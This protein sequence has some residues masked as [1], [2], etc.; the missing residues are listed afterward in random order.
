MQN[1]FFLDAEM[2]PQ[3]NPAQLT[4]LPALM[5]QR[6][7]K[8]LDEKN[9]VNYFSWFQEFYKNKASLSAE[10]GKVCSI[11]AG[12]LIGDKFYLKTI[13]DD[14][15]V[16]VL[17]ALT[18]M[19]QDGKVKCNTLVGHNIIDFDIP[20]LMRRYIVHRLPIPRLINLMLVKKMWEHPV[21][22]T[23]KMWG[24]AQFNYRV[25]LDLLCE[26]FGIPSAK[27]EISGAD[28]CDLYYG[29]GR[30]ARAN[31]TSDLP[32]EKSDALKKIG[33]YNG[34]DVVAAARVYAH[35]KNFETI[36]DNQIFNI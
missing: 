13:A 27:K 6:Y 14:D 9:P 22:D 33:V 26:T 20:F 21:Y 3:L 5:A 8:E 23:M 16:K 11:S 32:W 15:E 30:F 29:N 10:F 1:L 2:V 24:A 12:V 17:L 25:S 35:I 7:R 18:E 36:R 19:L 34:H 31:D 4:E 28:V